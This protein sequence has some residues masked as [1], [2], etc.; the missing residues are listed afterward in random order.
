[1][2][3]LTNISIPH[4]GRQ[5]SLDLEWNADAFAEQGEA[6]FQIRGSVRDIGEAEREPEEVTL[7]VR[8][9]RDEQDSLWLNVEHEGQ[10]IFETPIAG[11][12]GLDA[13]ELAL[14]ILDQLPVQIVDPLLGCALRAGLAS[15]LEQSITCSRKLEREAGFVQQGRQ[16]LGCLGSNAE[17]IGKSAI[18][19]FLR[20]FLLM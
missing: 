19:R 8:F 9:V 18:V 14:E 10:L 3:S 16:F 1:M 12:G 4:E 15:V 5:Y 6:S 13:G 2:V 20:C 7:D 11:L 17:T